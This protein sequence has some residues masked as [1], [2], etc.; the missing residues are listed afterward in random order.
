MGGLRGRSEVWTLMVNKERPEQA[1]GSRA[2]M[3]FCQVQMS[4]LVEAG[5]C[6]NLLT[7]PL[8]ELVFLLSS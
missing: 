4:Y 5:S 3:Y 6:G 7:F 2:F 8:V 1:L